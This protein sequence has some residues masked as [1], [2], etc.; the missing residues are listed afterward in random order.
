MT[1]RTATWLIGITAALGCIFVAT[2]ANAQAPGGP[3]SPGNVTSYV[4]APTAASS[5]AN[6]LRFAFF[7]SKDNVVFSFDVPTITVGMTAA[8]KAAAIYAAYQAAVA[9][10]VAAGKPAPLMNFVD[11]STKKLAPNT[12]SILSGAM[13]VGANEVPFFSSLRVTDPTGEARV[14]N[15]NSNGDVKWR[16]A[17]MLMPAPGNGMGKASGMDSSGSQSV[18]QAGIVT[19]DDTTGIETDLFVATVDPF[20]GESPDS[21]LETLATDLA[22][23]GF[24]AQ[25]DP[26]TDELDVLHIPAGDSFLTGDTDTGLEI[27]TTTDVNDVPEPPAS[28]IFLTL[29]GAYV[30]QRRLR[31]PKRLPE[32]A[33]R[34]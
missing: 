25:F 21:I 6:P 28:W 2:T 20:A 11:P 12:I 18:V 33:A 29:L 23:N 3:G 19:V 26:A 22:D 10:L 4:T 30:F 8:Q 17:E 14:I 7:D 27:A 31:R 1:N 16:A 32:F 9:A 13:K 24:D 5:A 15:R 34:L